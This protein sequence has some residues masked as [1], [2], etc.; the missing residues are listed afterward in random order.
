MRKTSA[1][2]LVE[3]LVVIAIIGILVA[4]LLPAVQAA[5]E[6][7]RRSQCINNLKQIG[8]ALHNYH[9]TKGQ[10]PESQTY[11]GNGSGTNCEPG[12]YSW[13]SMLLPFIEENALYDSID[14]SVNMAGSC[15]SGDGIDNNHPNAIAAS[16]IVSGFLCPSDNA[17]GDN[18]VLLGSANPASD[19]YAANAGWPS[20]ATGYIGE[21]EA[22]KEYNGIITLRNPNDSLAAEWLPKSG[23]KL[24]HI[25][26]GTAHTAAVS[27][28]LIQDGQTIDGIKNSGK[29]YLSFHVPAANVAD[30]TRNTLAILSQ[31]CNFGAG[32]HSDVVPSAYAGR[33]WISGWAPTMP[34]YMHLNVPN[35]HH[36]HFNDADQNGNV[37]ATPSSNH[38]GGVVTLMCDGHIEFIAD[39]IEPE[40]WWALGS[41]N[42]EES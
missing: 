21:R 2:T 12:F 40:T 22:N 42:G 16:T 14:F 33:A 34:T 36:C 19:S 23:I 5:R 38:K 7:A 26:D 3:L 25:T 28:R 15:G 29:V 17:N 4:L 24:K 39:Q 37:P 6:A 11:S 32:L 20:L 27:E 10:F 8:L 31:G 18:A 1:F 13:H 35:T 30:P 9:D 41:R